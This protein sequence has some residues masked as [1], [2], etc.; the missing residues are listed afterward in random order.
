MLPASICVGGRGG[1][2][3]GDGLTAARSPTCYLALA[4]SCTSMPGLLFCTANLLP[5]VIGLAKRSLP[6]FN[7]SY[8]PVSAGLATLADPFHDC[9]PGIKQALADSLPARGSTRR[10]SFPFWFAWSGPPLP[11]Y[12]S[13]SFHHSC[14]M[15]SCGNL[16]LRVCPCSTDPSTSAGALY[17]AGKTV[18]RIN[19]DVVQ[20]GM[21]SQMPVID[22]VG[23][24]AGSTSRRS[25]S[26]WMLKD[27][28]HRNKIRPLARLHSELVAALAQAKGTR[29]E[30]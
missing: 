17:R 13:A 7:V 30:V 23:G 28:L 6:A 19:H 27:A 9:S 1:S 18:T 21:A 12:C 2:G 14:S 5:A 10:F 11:P 22:L 15:S 4:L 24:R 3:F 20:R 16:L 26:V 8:Q 29:N 25:S